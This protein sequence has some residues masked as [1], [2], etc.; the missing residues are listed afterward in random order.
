MTKNLIQDCPLIMILQFDKQG[1]KS[2]ADHTCDM[3]F[4]ISF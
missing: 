2:L 1:G 4:A 3:A